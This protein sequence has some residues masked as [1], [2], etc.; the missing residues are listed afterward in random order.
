MTGQIVLVNFADAKFKRTQA[1]QGRCAKLL[2]FEEIYAYSELDLDPDFISKHQ[3]TFSEKRGFGY[4]LWKPWII[5]EVCKRVNQDATILYLDSAVIPKIRATSFM[6]QARDSLIHV[7]AEDTLSTNRNYIDPEVWDSLSNSEISK[8]SIH[9]WA[10]AI[11]SRN[12]SSFQNF[13][14]EWLR[15]CSEPQLLHPTT[16]TLRDTDYLYIGHRHD[17]AL[18]NLLILE[19]PTIFNLH[20]KIDDLAPNFFI[21]H[22]SNK[23]VNNLKLTLYQTEKRT[24]RYILKLLPEFLRFHLFSVVTRRRRPATSKI[25][26][27][28]AYKHFNT[29]LAN[30]RKSR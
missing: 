22:R 3:K 15:L 5:L 16:D 26:V 25:E 18:M 17:Q 1:F 20:F 8:D 30:S 13:L 11:L 27:Q 23:V 9:Y 4:W 14:Q 10:G 29:L 21:I 19:Q 28:R 7:W 24:Y 2:G 12:T 6:E